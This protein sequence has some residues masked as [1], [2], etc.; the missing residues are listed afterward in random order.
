MIVFDTETRTDAAQRLTFGSYRCI[1]R[2]RCIEE[3]LFHGEDLSAKEL[4]TLRRY[5]R[6]HK[7]DTVSAGTREL[8]LITLRRFVKELFPDLYKTRCMLVAFNHPF[9]LS[10]IAR[11]YAKVHAC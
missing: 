5:V 10:R 2:R 4:R 1:L 8:R 3:G 9:D 11:G 7:P 6:G